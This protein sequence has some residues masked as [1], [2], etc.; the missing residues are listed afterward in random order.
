MGVGKAMKE[1]DSGIR[2]VE[3]HPV[4]GHYIQ[5]L[6]N[7]NEAIVPSIYDPS[8]IDETIMVETEAAYELAREIVHKE[9]IF[10]G[11]SSGAAMYAAIEVAKK[12]DSGSIAMIFPD[13]GEKY[14]ST[15]LFKG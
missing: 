8:M 7:M 9:G 2:I 13:R 12:I 6:K 4:K 10:V 5:G 15:E 3:A 14:L 1:K 11:M